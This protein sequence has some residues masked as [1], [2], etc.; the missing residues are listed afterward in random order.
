[1]LSRRRTI[2]RRRGSPLSGANPNR[3]TLGQLQ[4]AVR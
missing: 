2:R 1:M 4:S 3:F